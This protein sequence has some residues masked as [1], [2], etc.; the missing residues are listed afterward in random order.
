MIDNRKKVYV[1]TDIETTWHYRPNATELATLEGMPKSINLAFD[2]A[3]KAVDRHG[4]VYAKGSYVATD[5]FRYAIPFFKQKLGLYIE[6]AFEHNLAPVNFSDVRTRFN[7][8]LAELDAQNFNVILTAYNAAFDFSHLQQTS[9]FLLNDNFLDR[10]RPILDIWHTWGMTVPLSYA[11]QASRTASGMYF[12]STA[13]AAYAFETGNSDFIEKHVAWDDVEIETELLI[14]AL[15]R[16][17]AEQRIITENPAELPAMC[18]RD[19]NERL[20]DK[21]PIT[22]VDEIGTEDEKPVYKQDRDF[23]NGFK[24][25]FKEFQSAE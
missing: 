6:D 17:S 8:D 25:E 9:E 2:T 4:N 19:I 10:P 14:K 20:Q 11:K 22:G 21:H 15:K 24:A 12:A 5:C 16:S 23:Q 1:V 13:E 7:A 3:W 18:W